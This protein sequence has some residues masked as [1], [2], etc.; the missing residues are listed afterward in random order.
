MREGEILLTKTVEEMLRKDPTHVA[1]YSFLNRE[2][3]G[4]KE[5]LQRVLWQTIQE[6]GFL[7]DLVDGVFDRDSFGIGKRTQIETHDGDTI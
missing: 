2:F 1:V 3:V 7:H 4:H 5:L 6:R